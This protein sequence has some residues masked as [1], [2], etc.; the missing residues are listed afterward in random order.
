MPLYEYACEACG[1]CF[2]II[3]KF[4]DPPVEKCP[5]CGGAVHKL[6][7]APAFQFK[8]SGWY[9]TDYA[10]TGKPES[11]AE[12]SEGSKAEGK[13]EA[14]AEGKTEGKAESKAESKAEGQ[15]GR[16]A[17]SKAGSKDTAASSSK[18]DSTESTKS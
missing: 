1:H 9:I 15:E 6:H 10:K 5:S 17:G 13:A 3:R 16:K 8:G 18:G 4:S 12:G 11:K 2:E 7:S 14:K